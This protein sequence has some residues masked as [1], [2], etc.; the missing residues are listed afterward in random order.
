M[1]DRKQR[2]AT[3]SQIEQLPAELEKLVSGAGERELERTYREGA[4]TVRQLVHHLADAH[5]NAY[6]RTKLTLTEDRPTVKPYNQDE[7]SKLQDA[8]SLPLSSS[9]G[10]I[11][12]VHHRWAVLIRSIPEEAW[13]RKL[14]HPERGEMTL[15]DLVESWRLHGE[16]HL[17]QIRI[18]LGK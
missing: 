17:E 1:A 9:L 13:S 3:I 12:G 11:R 8:R 10:I 7:W 4:W 5:A 15:E 16:T 18:A 14:F 6:I 2:E